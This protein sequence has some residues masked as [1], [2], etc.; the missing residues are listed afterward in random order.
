MNELLA[1]APRSEVAHGVLGCAVSLND[2]ADLGPT[3]L[4]AMHGSCFAGD[5]AEA[6]RGL[7]DDYDQRLSAA[8]R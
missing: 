2:L 1:A 7:A 6:L 4:A 8:T 5:G 3:R